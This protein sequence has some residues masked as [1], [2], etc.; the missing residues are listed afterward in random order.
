MSNCFNCKN[1]CCSKNFIGLVN[2][3]KND[4]SN[5]F[6]QILLNEEEVQRIIKGGGEK[7]IEKIFWE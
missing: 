5:L 1:N 7:Y 3:F 6:N 4:D 2:S